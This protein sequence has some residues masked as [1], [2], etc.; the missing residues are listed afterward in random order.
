MSKAI[1]VL[2]LVRDEHRFVFLYDDNSIDTLLA[3]FSDYASDPELE[4]SW[5]DAAVMAQRV[6]EMLEDQTE[7][8]HRQEDFP[9][10]F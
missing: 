9:R 4:F 2:A 10:V 8:F 7:G 3:T 6:R 1:N 5:Y